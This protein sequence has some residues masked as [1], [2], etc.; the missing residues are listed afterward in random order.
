MPHT[1]LVSMGVAYLASTD[2]VAI[3]L[4]PGAMEAVKHLTARGGRRIAYMVSQSGSY[5]SEVRYKAYTGVL[6]EAGLKPEYIVASS[7]LRSDA[8]QAM[9]EHIHACG[10]PDGI[11]FFNDDMAIGA[12]RAL[13]DLGIRV[14][15]DVA[16]VG[17]DNIED[18]EYLEVRL[19][20]IAQPLEEMCILAWQFLERRMND[21]ALPLQQQF[22]PA[23]LI[24][25][26]SS[27]R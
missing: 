26:E 15:D 7:H 27:C 18:T 21:P 9:L 23:K 11:F 16:L 6:Q 22:L 10:C 19:S 14:P 17:C 5:A 12:Y 4:Y 24:I 25:R 13:C 20:T 8:C 1:P 3:D 2:L